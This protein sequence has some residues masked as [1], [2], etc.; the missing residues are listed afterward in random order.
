MQFSISRSA[1]VSALSTVYG[2]VAKRASIPILANV[3]LSVE[4]GALSLTT[5]DLELAITTHVEANVTRDGVITVPAR[6]LLDYVRQLSD[7]EIEISAS[8]TDWLTIRAKRS[9]TRIPGMSDASFPEVPAMPVPGAFSVAAVHLA[10]LIEHVKFAISAIE[11]RFTLNGALVEM[12]GGTL[13]LVAT[14]GHR[15]AYDQLITPGER[16][17]ALVSRAALEQVAKLA[18]AAGDDAEVMVSDEENHVF[19]SIGP[20]TLISRKLS[21]N[22]PDYVR[23]FPKE[24]KIIATVGRE[25]LIDALGRVVLFS[26]E[27]SKAVRLSF[28]ADGLE[29]FASALESGEGSDTIDC[30]Y[31]GELAIGFNGEYL[32]HYL[33]ATKAARVCLCLTDEKGA[34]EMH[35]E[36]DTDF[37]YV[38]MPMRI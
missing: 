32:K 34:M 10:R 8:E 36:G 7:G 11:S 24:S 29:L 22:F 25:A 5:T 26:D 2:A 28:G 20:T 14:D 13:K 27:R 31:T 6:K 18:G 3:R 30:D 33:N 21:G 4:A 23:V 38:V 37:R 1:L 17:K 15:L 12:L 16:F 19:F 35:A 9:R